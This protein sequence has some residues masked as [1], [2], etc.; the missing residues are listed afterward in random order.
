MVDAKGHLLRS[1]RGRS[2][3]GSL[4]FGLN[5]LLFLKACGGSNKYV[6]GGATDPALSAALANAPPPVVFLAEKKLTVTVNRPGE[7]GT[8]PLYVELSRYVA[9]SAAPSVVWT[10]PGGLPQGLSLHGTTG[11]LRGIPMVE[12]GTQQFTIAGKRGDSILISVLI[13]IQPRSRITGLDAAAL[14]VP[15][16]LAGMGAAETLV[17][18]SDDDE[19]EG[20]GSGD[21]IDGRD[22]F[23]F[24][25]YR[26]SPGPV[27]VDLYYA[28]L[29]QNNLTASRPST[30][31]QAASQ[32]DADG[33]ELRN[34]EGVIGSNHS[35][36][37]NGDNSNNVIFGLG[38]QDR[39]KGRG[40]DDRLF[41]GDDADY[42]NGG[43]G[44]DLL[45]GGGDGLGNTAVGDTAEYDDSP[46]GIYV[47]LEWHWPVGRRRG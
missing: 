30:K 44:A 17:G 31:S 19:L 14:R 47:S 11:V 10:A 37:L 1:H 27:N 36:F 5:L 2:S 29:L 18:G 32:H 43:P 28:S 20:K 15:V 8:H 45:V 6:K 38:G 3:P 39:I 13:E 41:G 12:R 26:L 16:L 34:I 4:F 46:E 40:G 9:A 35:D 42:L 33:D 24:A 21:V 25:S 23:D 22:G 7:G